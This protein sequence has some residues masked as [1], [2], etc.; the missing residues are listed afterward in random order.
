MKKEIVLELSPKAAS[1]EDQIKREAAQKLNIKASAIT[2]LKVIRRSIDARKKEVKI[3]LEVLVV[4]SE[5]APKF[6]RPEFHFQF[7]GNKPAVVIVGAGP[8]GLFAALRLI[9]LGM[10]PIV[11][12]RGKEV[13][14]RKID[15]A[16]LAKEQIVN[17]E[18]NYCFGE[19][20]AGTFSDGKLYTRSKKKGENQRILE[21]LQFHGAQEEIL[22]D[23]HPHIGTNILPRVIV[24]IR[25]SI[26]QA[27]GEIRFNTRVDDLIIKDNQVLGVETASDDK[28]HGK[29][30][31]LATGHSSRDMYEL[32]YHRDIALEAKPFAMGVRIEH[33]QALIDSIQYHCDVRS[34]YLPAASYNMVAQVEGRGVYS[35]C[36]CPG[37]YIVP[38]A[39]GPEEIVV[40]GMSPSGRNSAFANSGMVVEIR[41]EDLKEYEEFGPLAGLKYQQQLEHLAYENANCD[42]TAPAQRMVDFVENRFSKDL[43]ESS[44]YCGTIPSPLHEWLPGP[45]RFRLQE[46]FKLFG[47]KYKGYLTNQAVILGVE[48][49]TSS[50]VRIPRNPDTLEHP[51]IKGLFPAGEGS[52]YAGGI[53]SSAIDGQRCAEMAA[54]L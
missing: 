39:T 7:V 22:T 23:A 28:I 9:E 11:L 13:S 5:P 32:L 36:M 33:P 41:L 48:S 27:G 20:G 29:A 49:R 52:G 34:K 4:F 45:I 15:I 21:L 40:N 26:L 50:P 44:Y 17:P 3:N 37:G 31:I 2:A 43:P 1:E 47:Q 51:Q 54:K 16:T 19:G 25:E 8:A 14:A 24:K 12:E 38:S 10:K 42:Q 46:A 30:V 35:F 53:V 6:P 18:S